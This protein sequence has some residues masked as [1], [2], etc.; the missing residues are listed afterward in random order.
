[1]SACGLGSLWQRDHE[2]GCQLRS[3]N[4]GGKLLF[5][6]EKVTWVEKIQRMEKL[7]LCRKIKSFDAGKVY[8][9]QVV[10]REDYSVL[11]RLRGGTLPCNGIGTG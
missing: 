11:A 5:Q 1:M 3:S 2:E 10:N 7:V 8:A 9:R 6:L 4:C